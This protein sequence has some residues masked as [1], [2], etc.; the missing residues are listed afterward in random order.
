MPTQVTIPFIAAQFNH[1]FKSAILAQVC[2]MLG[3]LTITILSR[4]PLHLAAP[5][6]GYAK[7]AFSSMLLTASL[8]FEDT[9][10]HPQTFHLTST[11]RVGSTIH[12]DLL[13]PDWQRGCQHGWALQ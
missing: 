11:T 8:R 6:R 3:F 13:A 1:V 4:E 7:N 10:S 2:T 5:S 12:L 9:Y